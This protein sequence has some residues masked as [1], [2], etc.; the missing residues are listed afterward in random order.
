M[1]ATCEAET[2]GEAEIHAKAPLDAAITVLIEGGR[3]NPWCAIC[4]APASDWTIDVNRSR[5]AT[6][7]EAEPELRRLQAEQIAVN[8]LFGDM[9]RND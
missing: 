3:M 6:M 4:H 7:A 2:L 5:F 9:H 1:A 8:A